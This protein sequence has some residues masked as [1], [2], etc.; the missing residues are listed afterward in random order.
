MAMTQPY[1]FKGKESRRVSDKITNI[2][3]RICAFVV[4]RREAVEDAKREKELATAEIEALVGEIDEMQDRANP[5]PRELMERLIRAHDNDK[6]TRSA[7]IRKHLQAALDLAQEQLNETDG[8]TKQALRLQLTLSS[9]T[10]VKEIQE[11]DTEY[12]QEDG[13]IY[14]PVGGQLALIKTIKQAIDTD[15]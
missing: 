12:R 6:Q 8:A 4:E 1:K 2:D 3:D 13:L 7:K 10:G 15:I 9:R 11:I 14:L 5:H